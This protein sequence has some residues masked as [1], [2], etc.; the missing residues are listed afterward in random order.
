MNDRLELKVL[1]NADAIIT[2]VG[3]RYHKILN[4]KISNPNKNS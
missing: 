2:T 4:S 1:E 3:D